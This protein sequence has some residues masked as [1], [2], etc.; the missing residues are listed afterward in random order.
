MAEILS[1]AA[2]R[3]LYREPGE[4]AVKK[5]LDRLDAHCRRFVSLSP[6]LVLASTDAKDRV[7]ASPRGGDPGFVK[8]P[9]ERTLLIPDSPG[10]NRLDSLQNLLDRPGVGLFF[11]IPGVD[12]TLRVNGTAALRTDEALLE[13]CANERRR[14]TLVI[15][16]TVEE[17]YLHCAKALMRSKLWDAS[18][19]QTRTVL[20]SMNQMLKDQIGLEGEPESDAAMRERY[21]QDL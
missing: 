12:E 6:F 20:P 15:A 1:L 8:A 5:Q 16:V 17:A 13:L 14:P 9:D 7:D 18:A 10:N 11:M 19:K 3:T 4:R 2:L 21:R